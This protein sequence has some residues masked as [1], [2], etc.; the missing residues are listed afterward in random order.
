MG[1]VQS[2]MV[3]EIVNI[4]GTLYQR[5][6]NIINTKYYREGSLWSFWFQSEN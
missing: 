6:L 2:L 5:T 4:L 1:S 3:F